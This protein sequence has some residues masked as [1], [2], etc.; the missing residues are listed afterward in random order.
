MV[1]MKLEMVAQLTNHNFGIFHNAKK[2]IMP[3]SKEANMGDVLHL[4]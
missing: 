4:M 3:V 2:Y 1:D